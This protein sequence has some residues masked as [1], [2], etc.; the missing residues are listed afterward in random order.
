MTG[1]GQKLMN[2]SVR[3]VGLE[4]SFDTGQCNW[5]GPKMKETCLHSIAT[6]EIV[7]IAVHLLPRL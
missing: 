5:Q 3:V 4:F 2:D 1:R 6:D 7:A